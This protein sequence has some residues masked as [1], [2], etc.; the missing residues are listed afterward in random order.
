[1]YAVFASSSGDSLV[2][3]AFL[4]EGDLTGRASP[5]ER[6]QTNGTNRRRTRLRYSS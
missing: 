1:M 6:H 4:G 2:P 3:G 5:D